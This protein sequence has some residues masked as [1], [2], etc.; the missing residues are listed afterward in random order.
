MKLLRAAFIGV[1][2]GA[3]LFPI[4]KAEAATRR[5]RSG[6]KS[7]QTVYGRWVLRVSRPRLMMRRY[8]AASPAPAPPPVMS[9]P[10][11][12]GPVNLPHNRG[13]R[14]AFAYA[15]PAPPP[16]PRDLA[17]LPSIEQDFLSRM[18]AQHVKGASVKAAKSGKIGA[19]RPD[20]AGDAEVLVLPGTQADG[21]PAAGLGSGG[22]NRDQGGKPSGKK[23]K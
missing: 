21:G 3:M 19:F 11:E 10:A 23:G 5:I 6:L 7:S 14:G 8:A 2:L 12:P 4:V 9:R 18:A 13:R 22:H 16:H 1:I 17:P 20:E 15:Q